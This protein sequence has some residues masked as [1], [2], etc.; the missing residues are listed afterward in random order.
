MAKKP[1]VPISPVDVVN[2]EV[3]MHSFLT[4]AKKTTNKAAASRARV[5]SIELEKLFKAYRYN[6]IKPSSKQ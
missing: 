3:E 1:V 5:K 4:D 2:L 6:S